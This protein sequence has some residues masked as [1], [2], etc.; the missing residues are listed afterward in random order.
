MS[1]TKKERRKGGRKVKLEQFFTKRDIVK[2]LSLIIHELCPGS[3]VDSSCGNGFLVKLLHSMGH[4]V[5]AYDIDDSNLEPDI[6]FFEKRDWLSLERGKVPFPADACIGF[7]PPFGPHCRSIREF[8]I[9]ALELAPDAPYVFFIGPHIP[10]HLGVEWLPP[11]CILERRIEL[12]KDSFETPSGKDFA[13]QTFFHIWKRDPEGHA[14][15]IQDAKRKYET[16]LP[17][18]FSLTK[19][20]TLLPSVTRRV[21]VQ[22]MPKEKNVLLIRIGG[23]QSGFN[24]IIHDGHCY[25][26]CTYRPKGGGI[27]EKVD[28]DDEDIGN[29][30]LGVLTVPDH[31]AGENRVK[32]LRKISPELISI[33][34]IQGDKRGVSK[35]DIRLALEKVLS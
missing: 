24:R 7:N 27:V 12:D 11:D 1:A 17:S 29:Q 32:L 10:G 15:F 26:K 5:W 13:Y 31:W 8:A 4:D 9:K 2:K 25:Q 23:V 3:F 14:E 20:C 18:G 33:R 34:K 28:F 35:L 30:T 6:P 21:P 19:M 16:P 22:S